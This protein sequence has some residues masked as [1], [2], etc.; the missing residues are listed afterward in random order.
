MKVGNA[1]KHIIYIIKERPGVAKAPPI[2]VPCI[3]LC[4]Y[5]AQ[6]D[7]STLLPAQPS[8]PSVINALS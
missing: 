7:Q 5:Y 1:G 6:F 3:K 4:K 2:R 8:P